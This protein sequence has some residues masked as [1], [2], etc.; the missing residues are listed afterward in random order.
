MIMLSIIF[1]LIIAAAVMGA[2]VMYQEKQYSISVLLALL[3]L[4]FTLLWISDLGSHTPEV[5]RVDFSCN[6]PTSTAVINGVHYDLPE[7]I[8]AGDYIIILNTHHT[9]DRRDDTIIQYYE[10]VFDIS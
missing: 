8:P 10:K 4:I 9:R 3:T 2:I 6:H 1:I 7:Q 5:K